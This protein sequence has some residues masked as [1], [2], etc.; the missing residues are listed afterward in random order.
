MKIW[1]QIVS[2]PFFPDL[3]NNKIKYIINC[4]NQFDKKIENNESL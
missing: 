3:E 1:K 2:L 4:I